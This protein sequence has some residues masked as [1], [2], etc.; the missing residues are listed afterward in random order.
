MSKQS[1]E[2]S[3]F[4]TIQRQN[5]RLVPDVVTALKGST[6]VRDVGNHDKREEIVKQASSGEKSTL[7]VN[8]NDKRSEKDRIGNNKSRW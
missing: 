4:Q 7:P 2:P 1:D 5:N 6:D 3:N 8:E